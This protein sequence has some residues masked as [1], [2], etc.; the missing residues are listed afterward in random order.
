MGPGLDFGND[1]REWGRNPVPCR[2][3]ILIKWSYSHIIFN[4]LGSDDF[5]ITVYKL[6]S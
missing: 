6:H 5:G 3:L 1:C 2:A 4:K